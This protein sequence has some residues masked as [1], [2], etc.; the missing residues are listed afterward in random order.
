MARVRLGERQFAHA[1]LI[2]LFTGIFYLLTQDI[3]WTMISFATIA[4]HQAFVVVVWRRELVGNH[5]TKRFGRHFFNIFMVLSYTLFMLRFVSAIVASFMEKNTLD[6]DP[7]AIVA[8]VVFFGILSMWAI[9]SVL[10]FFGLKRTV[11]I[12]HFQKS[13][14]RDVPL[15]RTGIFALS[16]N[17][18]YL[19][20]MLAFFIPAF[21]AES[22]LGIYV[23]LFNYCA[24]WVHYWATELPDMRYIYGRRLR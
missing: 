22:S 13:V 7:L 10:M 18:M 15:V 17:A 20:G 5:L 11:G 2:L 21:L 16:R 4:I 8:L 6:V 9:L 23:A 3:M 1:S 19:L 24:M 12:D 14:Y